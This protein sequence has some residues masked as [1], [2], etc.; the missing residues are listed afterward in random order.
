MRG[1]TWI[2]SM[3]PLAYR[4]GASYVESL[5]T[6]VNQPVYVISGLVFLSGVL[7]W[8]WCACFEVL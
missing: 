6:K 2:N 5:T 1:A 8:G 3:S 7:G 4:V